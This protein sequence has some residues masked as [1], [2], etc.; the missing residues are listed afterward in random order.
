[1]VEKETLEK[2]EFLK[3]LPDHI[4]EKIG[5]IAR[6]SEYGEEQILFRQ[7]E[8][9]TVLYMLVSG[10]VFLNSRAGTGQSLTLDAVYPG[11]TFGVPA[12]LKESYG[13]FSAIC[14]EPCT[15]ITIQAREMRQLFRGDFESGY[16]LM[17]R[18]VE[19]FKI[20]GEMHTHQ[21]LHSLKTHPEIKKFQD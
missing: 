21:F 18:V 10:K 9:Q 3:D 16:I 8:I 13:T 19:L 20:R 4:L 6:I 1:M 5:S 2:I 11:R 7:N 15:M 17:R 12:L 14:A